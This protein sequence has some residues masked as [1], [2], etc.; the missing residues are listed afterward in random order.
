MELAKNKTSDI[1]IFNINSIAAVFNAKKLKNNQCFS[2][3]KQSFVERRN[4]YEQLKQFVLIK[5]QKNLNH[6]ES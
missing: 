2:G 5:Q 1:E 4:N 3:Y 6:L